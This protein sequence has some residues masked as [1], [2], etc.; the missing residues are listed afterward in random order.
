MTPD[1]RRLAVAYAILVVLALVYCSPFLWM[2]LQSLKTLGGY[3]T[4]PPQLPWKPQW[5]NYGLLLM[6]PTF[7]RAGLNSLFVSTAIA[8]LQ[9]IVSALAAFAF[10]ALRFRGRAAIFAIVIATLMIPST[11]TIIP[12]F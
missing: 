4:R 6:D 7:I 2:L 11:A 12:L 1:R 10:A 3:Y 5:A 8:T 9:V